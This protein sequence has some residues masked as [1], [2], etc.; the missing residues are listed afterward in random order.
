M[1]IHGGPNS[2]IEV[3]HAG[4]KGGAADYFHIFLQ[5]EN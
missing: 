5:K 2:G 3:G 4:G 1:W